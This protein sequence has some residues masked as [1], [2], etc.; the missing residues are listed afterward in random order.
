M[1]IKNNTDCIYRRTK[2]KISVC[3][4]VLSPEK[5]IHRHAV[6]NRTIDEIVAAGE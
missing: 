5:P 2:T 6:I 4:K 3:G 1:V